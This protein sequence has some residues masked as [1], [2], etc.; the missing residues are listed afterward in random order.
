LGLKVTIFQYFN[1]FHRVVKMP[2]SM[3]RGNYLFQ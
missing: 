1:C 2:Y 3:K